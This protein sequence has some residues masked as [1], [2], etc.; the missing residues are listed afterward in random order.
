MEWD[1]F[2]KKG[3]PGWHI[4]CS[5]MAQKYLGD[6]FDIHTGGIDLSRTHHIN[7]IAQSETLLN[8]KPY[9]NFWLHGEFLLIRGEKMSKSVGNLI[10]VQTLKNEGFDPISY[11]FFVLQAHFQ[12]QLNFTFEALKSAEIGLKNLRREIEKLEELGENKNFREKFRNHLF[13]NL[14]TAEAIAFLFKSVDSGLISKE[15]VV[16]A[17]KVLSLNLITEK[18]EIPEEILN[19]IEERKKARED[20]N[21]SKSDELRTIIENLGFILEDQNGNT[22]VRKK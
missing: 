4:E 10:T 19:L 15:D 7:E 12:K 14:N 20:K 9:V 1:A 18:I 16:F 6:T 5:A 8:K 2:Q 17:D 21:W 13:D 11:R 3:F 22:V